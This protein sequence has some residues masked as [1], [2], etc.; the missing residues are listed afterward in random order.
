MI[1]FCVILHFYNYISYKASVIKFLSFNIIINSQQSVTFK[2]NKYKHMKTLNYLF[3]LAILF[4]LFSCKSDTESSNK[5]S[6]QITSA[7]E[8]VQ[9]IE[10]G[11]DGMTCEIGCA[12]LIESKV[13]KLDGVTISKVNFEE[14]IGTFTFDVSKISSEEITKNINGIAGGDLYKV[15]EI[16]TVQ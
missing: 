12:K 8:A 5:N 1:L 9:S 10:V 15:T 16:K 14:K 6:N 2:N 7:K 13:S 11:I 3:T 4:T